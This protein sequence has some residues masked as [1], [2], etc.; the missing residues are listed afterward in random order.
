MRVTFIWDYQASK[1]E[2]LEKHQYKLLRCL[3]ISD[4]ISETGFS[5]LTLIK[6]SGAQGGSRVSN[7]DWSRLGGMKCPLLFSRRLAMSSIGPARWTNRIFLG[8]DSFSSSWLFKLWQPASPFSKMHRYSFLRA[9]QAK[10][11]LCPDACSL[12][13]LEFDNIYALGEK[14]WVCMFYF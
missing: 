1:Q 5:K 10:M 3:S 13:K 7:W 4:T 14:V 6:F 11:T 8:A 12:Q 9:E 2:N